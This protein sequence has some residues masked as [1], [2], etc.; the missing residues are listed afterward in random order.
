VSKLSVEVG[1]NELGQGDS[2]LAEA[3]VM[4][5]HATITFRDSAG[6][7]HTRDWHFIGSVDDVDFS[8]GKAAKVEDEDPGTQGVS[9]GWGP[10]PLLPDTSHASAELKPDPYVEQKAGVADEGRKSKAEVKKAHD[11][12]EKATVA[13]DSSAKADSK[14][15]KDAGETAEQSGA[16]KAE[17]PKS[18]SKK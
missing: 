16:G 12:A 4:A 1:E 6:R 2:A 7:D 15:G 11:A 13:T 14:K 5:A 3:E 9:K 8:I 17:A 10:R 18:D